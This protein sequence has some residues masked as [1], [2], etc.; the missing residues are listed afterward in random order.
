MGK[1]DRRTWR[2]GRTA[3][4][5][6]KLRAGP[7]SDSDRRRFEAWRAA[8]PANHA[9]VEDLLALRHR[10][11]GVRRM[12]AGQAAEPRRRRSRQSRSRMPGMLAVGLLAVIVAIVATRGEA[13]DYRTEPGDQ[14]SF[15]LADGSVV[16]MNTDTRINVS[17]NGIR[18]IEL[19]DGEADIIV[20]AGN[21]PLEVR[22]A[23]L[24]LHAGEGRLL[25]RKDWSGISLA[26][27][28]G[29]V[30]LRGGEGGS[31]PTE[32]AAG[33]V[34][35]LS[36]DGSAVFPSTLAI[37]DAAAWQEGAVVFEATPLD[38]ALRQID[39]Y[40]DS[41]LVILASRLADREVFGRYSLQDPDALTARL[42][43]EGEAEK[44]EI[45]G[46]YTLVY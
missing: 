29:A 23:D 39:R 42:V 12:A 16:F 6:A 5:T 37:E 9:A 24:R 10:D 18:Q 8:H 46:L 35:T 20:A 30:E 44:I 32:I 11:S 1:H 2:Q 17:E 19:L 33:A 31:Q 13:V 3:Y 45:L 15:A 36:D 41:R 28:D 4:W 38:E 26:V 27:I 34:V 25:L 7:L 21:P 40:R 22:V 14:G 43:R